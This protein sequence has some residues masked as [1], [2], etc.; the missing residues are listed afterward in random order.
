[1]FIHSPHT[2]TTH[3]HTFSH[4][5]ESEVPE[6]SYVFSNTRKARNAVT[7]KVTKKKK[8]KQKKKRINNHIMM[9]YSS[10]SSSSS[11]SL[12]SFTSSVSR[13]SYSIP[14]SISDYPFSSSILP[15][16]LSFSFHFSSSFSPFFLLIF[17]VSF[18]SLFFSSYAQDP[19]V[20]VPD[21]PPPAV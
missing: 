13:L 20:M 3:M 21:F 14:Y 7:K 11:C 15:S 10:S 4:N 17:L 8:N 16:S 19:K 1:L 5:K 6:T 9:G 18:C 12:P 2:H